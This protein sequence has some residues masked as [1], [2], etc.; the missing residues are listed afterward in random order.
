MKTW[1]NEVENDA[2]DAIA[3][4]RRFLRVPRE[5]AD[6]YEELAEVKEQGE[7][8]HVLQVGREVLDLLY[9]GAW[10]TSQAKESRVD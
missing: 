9:F 8:R 4:L 2:I 1:D 5:G 6:S 10:E 7:G 3:K